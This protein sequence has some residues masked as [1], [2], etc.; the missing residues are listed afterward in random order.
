MA[1]SKSDRKVTGVVEGNKKGIIAQE[2]SEHSDIISPE[3]LELYNK[4][5]PDFG[6]RYLNSI[7][8]YPKINKTENDRKYHLGK[9]SIYVSIFAI[10]FYLGLIG[11]LFFI[12]KYELGAYLLLGGIVALISITWKAQ[13]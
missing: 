6:E 8:E 13:R 5:M 11:F 3:D 1:K 9:I 7:L 4:I 2:I 12:Q 10:L